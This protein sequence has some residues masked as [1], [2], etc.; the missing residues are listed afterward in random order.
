M[1]VCFGQ[2]PFAVGHE[3]LAAVAGHPHAGR[4][5]SD[6]DEAERTTLPRFFQIKNRD[7]IDVGIGDEKQPFVRTQRQAV[8]G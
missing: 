3:K 2:D 1:T 7:G 6:R 8:R 4:V 5:P